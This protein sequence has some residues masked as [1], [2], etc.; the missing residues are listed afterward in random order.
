[1]KRSSV[2]LMGKSE[3]G[4]SVGTSGAGNTHVQLAYLVSKWDLEDSEGI[5]RTPGI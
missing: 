4:S 3:G 2:Q 5:R 1:M